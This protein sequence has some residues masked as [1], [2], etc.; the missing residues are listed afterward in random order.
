LF[1]LMAAQRAVM[2]T[3]AVGAEARAGALTAVGVVVFGACGAVT[4][5]RLRCLAYAA[6]AGMA[7]GLV[8]VYVHS[9]AVDGIGH[10]HVA[11]VVGLVAALPVGL[12]FVQHAYAAGPPQVVIACQTVIDPMLGVGVGLG[13]FGEATALSRSAAVIL[14][15]CAAVAVTGVALLAREHIRPQ[16]SRS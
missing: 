6:A 16:W 14:L 5:G 10:L 12:W 9:L 11:A 8:S 3:L 7:Y 15:A 1:V 4:T 13:L 2:P